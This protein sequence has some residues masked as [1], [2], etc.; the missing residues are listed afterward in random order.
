VV[1]LR[2]AKLPSRSIGFAVDL[3]LQVA[4]LAVALYLVT[5]FGPVVDQTLAGVI[6]F[7]VVLAVLVGYPVAME[8]LT[9]GRTFG[10][11]VLGLRVVGDDGS[12]ERFRH[13]LVRGLMGFVELYLLPFVAIICSLLSPE[14]KRVGDYLAGTIVVRE[15]APSAGATLPGLM[16]ELAPWAATLDLT[17]L[18]DDLML[19]VRQYVSRA[20]G[21]APAARRQIAAQLAGGLARYVPAQRPGWMTDELFCQTVLAERRRRAT[22]T[23]PVTGP[24]TAPVTDTGRQAA[25]P[26]PSAAPVTGDRPLAP[27][28]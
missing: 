19:Q 15:R 23:A 22:A 6:V 27:P 17:R 3:V 9:R 28:S 12:P 21:L 7:V 13:A 4:V 14:G 8:T 24:A 2:L 25:R 1:E 16:P 5:S 26:T 18:P 10:K 20:S 11:L